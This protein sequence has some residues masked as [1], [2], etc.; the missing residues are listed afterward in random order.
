LADFDN[1]RHATSKKTLTQMTIVLAKSPWYF[2]YTTLW[3][4]EVVV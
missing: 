4:A 1:F 3:K 2:R